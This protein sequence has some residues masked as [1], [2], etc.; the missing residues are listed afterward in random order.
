[1][2]GINT[3]VCVYDKDK[4]F[5]VMI[6]QGKAKED[7]VL[8]YVKKKVPPYMVPNILIKTSTMPLN[9]NGKIDRAFLKN[10][11]QTLIKN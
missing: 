8:D 5:I 4:D 10:N 7:A 9:Q 6:Y 1:M 11:Y 3:V 2:D